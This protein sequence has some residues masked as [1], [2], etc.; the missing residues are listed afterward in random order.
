M[1]YELIVI[2]TLVVASM[3]N[4]TIWYHSASKH[5]LQYVMFA[6]F[7]SDLQLCSDGRRVK[8]PFLDMFVD[9]L[10]KVGALF[11]RFLYII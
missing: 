6:Y 9:A 7:T 3:W 8:E 4:Y 1:Y 2:D 10:T 5:V 11:P